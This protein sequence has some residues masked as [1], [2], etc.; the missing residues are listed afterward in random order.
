M[1]LDEI[2]PQSTA[3]QTAVTEGQFVIVRPKT[4]TMRWEHTKIVR[5]AADGLEVIN[6]DDSKR[7]VSQDDV[8]PI[9]P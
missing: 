9:V 3:K 6:R 8:I 1:V 5:I 7:K 2:A 4:A